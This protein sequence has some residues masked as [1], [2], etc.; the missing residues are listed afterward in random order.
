MLGF[1]NTKVSTLAGI[2]ILLLITGAI[3]AMIFHEFHQII[4]IRFEVMELK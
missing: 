2:I 1:L 3:G 4:S